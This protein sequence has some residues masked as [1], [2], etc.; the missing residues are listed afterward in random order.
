R[1]WREHR[2]GRADGQPGVDLLEFDAGELRRRDAD[3]G[4]RL[5]ADVHGATQHR[6][7]TVELSFPQLVAEDDGLRALVAL[8]VG[9]EEAAEHGSCTECREEARR[10]QH[11]A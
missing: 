3:Y 5:E 6:R 2:G 1:A 10:D 7:V 11:D 8:L 9:R 4:V